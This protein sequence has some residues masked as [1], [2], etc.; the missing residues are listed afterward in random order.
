MSGLV[1]QLHC[2]AIA[3]SVLLA[4]MDNFMPQDEQ[5]RMAFSESHMKCFDKIEV[6]IASN[7]E[8]Y[9]SKEFPKSISEI[10]R[11]GPANLYNILHGEAPASSEDRWE[12]LETQSESLSPQS[13]S[14]QS[15][16]PPPYSSI[17]TI[18][19]SIASLPPQPKR[20]T[21]FP[22]LSSLTPW[23]LST[24]QGLQRSLDSLHRTRNAPAIGIA[25]V[26][27]KGTETLVTG[28]RK[29]GNPTPALPT[30]LFNISVASGLMTMT[31]LAR[32]ID[33]GLLS[34]TSTL[35]T[36][37][38]D[39]AE[40]LH[41]AHVHTTVEM[42]GAQL[43]G[44][45]DSIEIAEDAK[46]WPYLQDPSVSG[47]EGRRAVLLSYLRKPP[48]NPPGRDAYKWNWV[49][50]LIVGHIIETVTG[51]TYEEAMQ[52]ELFGPLGMRSAGFGLPDNIRNASSP[53][54]IQPFPH[55]PS[56]TGPPDALSPGLTRS[57]NPPALRPGDG[58]HASL[59]DLC[60]FLR[61]SLFGPRDKLHGQL[62]SKA[63]W[64]K[65]FRSSVGRNETAASLRKVQRD[66]AKG[67]AFSENGTSGGFSASFWIAPRVDK[68]FLCVVNMDGTAGDTVADE[69]VLLCTR[70]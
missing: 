61:V 39:F 37:L 19:P 35:P 27:A 45:S 22:P 42:F 57:T 49:N 38:P 54:P 59:S 11:K 14:D 43:S 55:S 3:M 58:I 7:R 16:L 32:L 25:L 36:I 40:L 9:K 8:N 10:T 51:R 63:S 6:D 64:E 52:A 24:S 41:P 2:Q 69:A 34:W 62:L 65:L 26:S 47:Y 66:W 12:L 53:D 31:V 50:R 28:V 13:E 20:P 18:P 44:I 46:L 60:T 23:K 70:Y 15:S 5:G 68:A 29:I 30:D 33:R 17:I 21:P 67:T 48:S 56:A 1:Q 4:V